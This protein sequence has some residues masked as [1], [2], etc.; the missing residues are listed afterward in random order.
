MGQ[1]TGRG[2]GVGSHSLHFWVVMLRRAALYALLLPVWIEASPQ[3]FLVTDV[4]VQR[5]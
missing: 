2:P 3:E 5:A 1:F 4:D